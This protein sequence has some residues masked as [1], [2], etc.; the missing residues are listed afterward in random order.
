M[1]QTGPGSGRPTVTGYSFSVNG[2][3]GFACMFT[4]STYNNSNSAAQQSG[5]RILDVR[6]AVVIIPF[7]PFTVG[8]TYQ[9]TVT[10][11]GETYSAEFTAVDPPY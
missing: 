5:R 1:I 4:E 11:D 10:I 9:V 8:N 3:P 2:S 7:N 6:D